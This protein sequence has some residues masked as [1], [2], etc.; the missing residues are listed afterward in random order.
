MLV[1]SEKQVRSDD[2]LRGK[3]LVTIRG[4]RANPVGEK[5]SS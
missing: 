2:P 5:R 4:D 1:P 3:A